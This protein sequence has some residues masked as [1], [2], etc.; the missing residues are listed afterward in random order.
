MHKL[1]SEPTNTIQIVVPQTENS[2]GNSKLS[3]TNLNSQRNVSVIPLE[4][5]A[6]TAGKDKIECADRKPNKRSLTVA[7]APDSETRCASLSK[8]RIKLSP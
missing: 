1:D 7:T 5:R 3:L 6:S 4:K 2:V 8:N